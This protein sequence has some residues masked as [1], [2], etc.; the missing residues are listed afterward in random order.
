[1]TRHPNVES[2][3]CADE[4]IPL[5]DVGFSKPHVDQ[6][7]GTMNIR[8]IHFL[9]YEILMRLKVERGV[10]RLSECS[11]SLKRKRKGRLIFSTSIS[12]ANIRHLHSLSLKHS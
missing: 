9:H 4:T 8:S 2:Q 3:G 7:F 6:C 1:M 5:G 10:L 12:R 11:E